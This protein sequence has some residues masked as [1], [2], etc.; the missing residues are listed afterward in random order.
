MKSI[1][2]ENILPEF[3]KANYGITLSSLLPIPIPWIFL[4]KTFS[5]HIGVLLLLLFRELAASTRN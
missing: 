5:P 1:L 3:F 4:T 2:H